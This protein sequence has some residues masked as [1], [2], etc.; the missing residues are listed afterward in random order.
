MH[1]ITRILCAA[2][3]GDPSAAEELLPLVYA[4][5]RCLATQKLS[6]ERPGQTLDPTGLVHEAYLRL[7][8]PGHMPADQEQHW[9][10]RGHFFAAAA[11]AMRRI[12]VESARRKRR[13]KHGGNLQRLSAEELDVA[14]DVPSDEVLAV[15][16]SLEKL[17]EV[18][19]QAAQVVKLHFFAGMTLEEVEALLGGP[20]GNYGFQERIVQTRDDIDVLRLAECRY[21]QWIDSRCMVGVQFDIDNRVVGKDLGEVTPPPLWRQA[22]ISL[23]P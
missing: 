10:G 15:D 5:L 12:L 9:D 11:E 1:D 8:P 14:I 4:E 6:K 16:E 22:L 19:P 7:V 3:D 18:D 21:L 17:A 13:L 20:A 23:R 2:H